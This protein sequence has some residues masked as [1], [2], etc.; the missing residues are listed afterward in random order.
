MEEWIQRRHSLEQGSLSGSTNWKPIDKGRPPLRGCI[1]F[2]S[3]SQ[4]VTAVTGTCSTA[5]DQTAPQSPRW[6]VGRESPIITPDWSCPFLP[7]PS[8]V[9]VVHTAFCHSCQWS[10]QK[11]ESC[12]LWPL[13]ECTVY[14]MSGTSNKCLCSQC[15]NN[16]R[17][18]ATMAM[19][20]I[21]KRR[22]QEITSQV[23]E[24]AV[25]QTLFTCE[26]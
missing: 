5:L 4:A 14:L 2:L 20:R 23:K 1:D 6:D 21:R 24:E 17:Q 16:P 3:S 8:F 7:L 25:S 11:Q 12:F 18:K 15:R 9:S 19:W 22:G 13:R 10:F 26:K